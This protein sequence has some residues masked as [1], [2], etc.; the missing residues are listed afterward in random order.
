MRFSLR[1]RHVVGQ[2]NLAKAADCAM[3]CYSFETLETNETVVMDFILIGGVATE[4]AASASLAGCNGAGVLSRPSQVSQ[5]SQILPPEPFNVASSRGMSCSTAATASQQRRASMAALQ[6]A[7]VERVGILPVRADGQGEQGGAERVREAGRR[8]RAGGRPGRADGPGRLV[9]L[10]C[11]ASRG[12]DGQALAVG[13][14]WAGRAGG[15]GQSAGWM[16]T[17]RRA[18][19]WG[20]PCRAC[21]RTQGIRACGA[22]AR[23]DINQPCGHSCQ[24]LLVCTQHPSSQGNAY[25][26]QDAVFRVHVPRAPYA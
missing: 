13:P 7:C 26:S 18:G 9:W 16:R 1:R 22:P 21:A 10:A 19:A 15:R 8:S 12:L 4:L 3:L 14:G 24:G 2:G 23:L 20:G 6:P 5:R 11:R 17:G 25:C